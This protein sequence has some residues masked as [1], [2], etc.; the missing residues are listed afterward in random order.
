MSESLAE[1]A[2]SLSESFG[3]AQFGD[4]R[5]TK[6]LVKIVERLSTRPNMS[7]PAATDGRAEMEAAYRFFDNSK[8]TPEAIM[9]PHVSATRERIR[10]T[11]VNLLV[12]D[13]TE[14]DITRPEQQVLGAGPIE[15]ESRVGA[16]YHPL[17]AFDATGLPLGTMWSR[18]GAREKIETGLTAAEKERKRK[19]TP[20]EEKESLRWLE[21]IRAA[22]DVAQACP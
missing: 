10:Q 19:T 1:S 16:S 18:C 15:C 9:A 21:G 6:R 5:L 3:S 4:L 20:I 12:Q 17:V 13:T 11:E 14:V 7:I 22:R 2:E 8:A